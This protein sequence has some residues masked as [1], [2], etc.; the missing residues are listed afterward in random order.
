MIIV[1][2][3]TAEH[4]AALMSF[5]CETESECRDG[6]LQT[7][8]EKLKQILCIADILL[9]SC[10][11]DAYAEPGQDSR[12]IAGID[13]VIIVED[14]QDVAPVFT[15][16]PPVTRLPSGL[17]P[18]DKVSRMHFFRMKLS[19]T[20]RFFSTSRYF[21]FTPRMATKAFREKSDTAWSQKA[22]RSL[23]SSISTTPPVSNSLPVCNSSH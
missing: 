12:N 17:I 15:L 7:R 3:L 11:Q 23:P 20:S 18:G 13:L 8:L 14:V 10:L 21:K 2:R 9:P 22:I 5:R 19:T 6:W 4:S 1:N 16:A